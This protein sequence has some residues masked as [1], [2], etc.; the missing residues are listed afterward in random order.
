M[1]PD[2]EFSELK[3][4]SDDTGRYIILYCMIQ[5]KYFL[6]INT[7]AP[8]NESDQ[9]TYFEKL[10]NHIS[11]VD[12]NDD[13]EILWGGDFNCC[14]QTIDSDDPKVILKKKTIIIL[15][16]AMDTLDI[17]DIW[18]IRNTDTL[19]YTWRSTNPLRQRRLDYI[20]ISNDL[21]SVVNVI[22]I[23]PAVATDHSA[24]VLKI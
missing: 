10:I 8:N 13:T 4:L 21:Q 6:I 7:Y 18:R 5:G 16:N 20:F 3:V 14:L 17:S 19:R 11:S 2:L 1:N 12:A 24:V 9:V 15:E 23:I 22:D